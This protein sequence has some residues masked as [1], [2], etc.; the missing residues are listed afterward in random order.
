MG[1]ISL[2]F[3]DNTSVNIN[4]PASYSGFD[5]TSFVFEG[6]VAGY[7]TTLK[8]TDISSS[9][10]HASLSHL[11][12][13]FP[14]ASWW[15]TSIGLLPYSGLGYS[16]FDQNYDEQI[17]NIRYDFSGEGGL[18]RFLW[19]NAFQP[20]H[21][22]SIGINSS[23]LFGTID[24]I[25]RVTFPDSTNMINTIINNTKVLNGITFD[26]GVQVHR[27]L[28][29][30]IDLIVGG[31]YSPKMDL[32]AK[33]DYL[34]RSY[35]GVVSGVEIVRDTVVI[36]NDQEGIVVL[37]AGYGVGFTLS[38]QNRWLVG[39]DYKA[40]NWSDYR[41]YGAS[42]SLV[43]SH[44]FHLGGKI[45]PNRNSLSYLQRVEYRAGG[46]YGRSYLDFRNENLTEFGITFGTGLPLRGT[47]L[48]RTMAMLNIGFEIGGKGTIKNGLIRENYFNTYLGISVY[49]W[50]FFKRRYN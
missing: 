22:L 35:S 40:N 33:R 21:F 41:T 37:P 45:V 18:S 17:G 30:N 24:K 11:L 28:G 39:F 31:T 49:E 1:G 20:V 12:F 32:N 10:F 14:I 19:G 27:K 4:N 50:W 34:M 7:S 38:R 16:V 29:D 44:S 23:Y 48:R 25:Q 47:L 43:N 13:G 6:G 42:D 5:S 46:Y 36:L 3:S 9:N 26:F 8:T 15:R 2:G